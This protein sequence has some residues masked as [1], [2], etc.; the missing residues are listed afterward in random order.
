MNEETLI[1]FVWLIPL[2]PLLAFFAIVLF[3]RGRDRLSHSIAI[4]A[5][6]ISLVLA[7]V[8]FWYA[9]GQAAS[10]W[11]SIRSK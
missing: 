6:A 11:P 7:Q 3:T 8:V 1:Y 5:M 2:L 9:M 10:T 4:G